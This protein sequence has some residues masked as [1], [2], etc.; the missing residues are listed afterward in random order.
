MKKRLLCLMASL[1]LCGAAIAQEPAY[2]RLHDNN[3]PVVAQVVLDEVPVT[4]S[5]WT[6]K[7]YIGDDQ[8]GEAVIQTSLNNTYWIQVYYSTDTEDNTP[9][10]FKIAN[11]TDEYTSET[12]LPAIP[13]GYGTPG[14]PQV[15]EFASMQTMETQLAS[16]WTWWSTPIEMEGN[17]G[18][19]QLENSINQ[20][21]TY[22]KSQNAVLQRRGTAWAGG[23]TSLQNEKSYRIEVSAPSSVVMT[24]VYADPSEHEITI[25]YGW[26]WIGYPVPVAQPINTALN[27]SGLTPTNG[28]IIKGQTGGVAQY[29][30]NQWIPNTYTLT[31][32]AVYMYDSKATNSK[33]FV[34]V[35]NTNNRTDINQS[36]EKDSFWA[37]DYHKYEN[38]MVVIAVVYIGNE[39]QK[40]ETLELG[41]FV[42]GVCTGSTRLFYV[43]EDDRY[44][45]AMTVGGSNGDRI[46]FGLVNEEKGLMYNSSDN[47][48]T[49]SND[50]V[51][52]SFDDPYEIHFNTLGVG[53]NS[54]HVAIYPNPVERGQEFKLNIPL[55]EEV[56]DVTVVNAL[57]A[58]AR[59]ELGALKNTLTGLPVSGVYTVKVS[60]QSGNV[61]YG[62]LIVK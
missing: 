11:G 8:R 1:L 40:D 28:D 47:N 57:G 41:A 9:V 18:L 6:L 14:T 48:L 59:H 39:E 52:G 5:E 3:M 38:N 31:P 34:F 46:S 56:V 24:G 4:T 61:Y 35:N 13:E 23:I 43:E 29:R 45:V 58:I 55:E 60:C 49:F 32:G 42:D 30:N 25:N 22:I 19:Q 2:V 26:N 53:E 7:A 20:Y 12:T 33:T 50:A 21:G 54:F 44:Y 51:V 36:I 15:I 27:G 62:R 16:G 37:A 10:T 17:N